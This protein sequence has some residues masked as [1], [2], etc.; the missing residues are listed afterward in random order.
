[1]SLHIE[2]QGQ[3]RDLILLHG[4]GVNSAVFHPLLPGLSQY[5]VHSVDLP[6]FGF[7]QAI[8]GELD[9]WVDALVAALPTQAVWLGWS[10]GGLVA[11]RVAQ[12]FPERVAGLITVASS[13]C[14]MA[15]SDN[16]WPGIAPNVLTQ[17]AEQLQQDLQRTI[18]K[19]LAIQAMGSDSAR[20][21]IR[22]I[23]ELVLARPLPNEQALAQGLEMLAKVD[24]RPG[25]ER[26]ALP[27]LRVWGRL[28]GLV[29]RRVA[30]L[31]PGNTSTTDLLLPKASHAPFISHPQEF[32][33]G[34]NS[35][36]TEKDFNSLP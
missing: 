30:N 25:L 15:R 36:L 11:T 9:D 8:D 32:I 5:R 35:W 3:G 26:L 28:D 10:L 12:R 21:D 1:M 16:Q 4:W 22:T 14:F 13:P 31:L 33:E 24:L 17:F 18:E 19:F 23:R 27:W 7:S 2:S 6:G 20:D 34:L 29:P